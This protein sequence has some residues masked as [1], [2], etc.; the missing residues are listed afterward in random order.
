MPR[1]KG[2]GK[3]K[4]YCLELLSE[5]LIVGGHKLVGMGWS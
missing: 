5:S 1:Q 2:K 3:K 4:G